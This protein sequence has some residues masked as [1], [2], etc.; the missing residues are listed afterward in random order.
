[1][2]PPTMSANR[3]KLSDTGTTIFTVMSA[4]AQKHSAINLSQGFPDFN[5]PEELLAAV[6]RHM[7]AGHNQYAPMPGAE[8]LRAAIASKI[9]RSYGT[10]VDPDTA[11]TVTSGATA[12]LFAAIMA[13]VHPG[14]EVII[15]DPAYDSYEPSIRLA[16]GRA[17]RLPLLPPQFAIDWNRVAAAITARTRM[18]IVNSP[19]NPTGATLSSMD[20]AALRDLV[21]NTAIT[22]LSDEVYEHI[23]FD[24]RQHESL[25]RDPELASRSL[26][27]SS[28]GKTYHMTGWKIGYC[29]A[30]AE[31][32]QEF[33]R[34]H[35]FSQFCVVSPMQWALAEFIEQHPEHCAELGNFYSTKRDRF[36]ALLGTS[37]FAIQPSAGTYFQLADYSAISELPD[38]EFTRWLT[39]EKG[40]AAIPVSVFYEFPGQI[41]KTQQL[42]RFCFAKNDSTLSNAA[43]ILCA[44]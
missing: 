9:Q 27:V 37:R 32:M 34:V 36:N 26:V 5:P 15:F 29:V 4:L 41:Q 1:M 14:D 2:E 10:A 33:R 8:V 17:V 38:T 3:S 7:D 25:L 23:I 22:L 39:I 6:T 42:I 13:L 19:H 28:F 31:L 12:A 44:I 11:V 18:I 24:G 40:V 20:I 30:P 43:E 35:Q 16:G 21:R